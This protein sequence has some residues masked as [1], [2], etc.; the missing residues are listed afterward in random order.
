MGGSSSR[1]DEIE[2]DKADGKLTSSDQTIDN[3]NPTDSYGVYYLTK[4]GVNQ[5]DYN[6]TDSDS[7][8]L[9]ATRAVEGTLAWFDVRGKEE[10]DYRLR[11]Q[12]DLSRRYW[13]VY[14]Y[15]IPA[16]R[17]QMWDEVSTEKSACHGGLRKPLFRRACITVTWARYHAVVDLYQPAPQEVNGDQ[18]NENIDKDISV[19][20][21]EEKKTEDVGEP[22]VINESNSGSNASKKSTMLSV[23]LCCSAEDISDADSDQGQLTPSTGITADR[24]NDTLNREKKDVIKLQS[25]RTLECANDDHSHG[26]ELARPRRMVSHSS[27]SIMEE[28]IVEKFGRSIL[29]ETV[30]VHR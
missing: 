30:S 13:V 17:G 5:R 16:F 8:L 18:N 19:G 15:G 25:T 21:L 1:F 28:D 2:W 14:N 9:Y 22:S 4:L 24:N 11:V 6:V 10:D 23:E 3:S 20:L 29:S 27:C 12:V 7:N 26:S